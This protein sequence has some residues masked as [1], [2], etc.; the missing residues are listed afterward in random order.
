MTGY[1]PWNASGPPTRTLVDF[2]KHEL[3]PPPPA[4][5]IFAMSPLRGRDGLE[6]RAYQGGP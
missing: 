6:E 1:E 5:A 3:P 2:R 4:G